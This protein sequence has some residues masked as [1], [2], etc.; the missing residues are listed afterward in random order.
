[1]KH[2]QCPGVLIECGF[3]SNPSEALQ[4]ETPEYQKKI[5]SIIAA[6]LTR[7]MKASQIT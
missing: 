5:S 3:I 2:I 1:M 7:N 6:T 4:L